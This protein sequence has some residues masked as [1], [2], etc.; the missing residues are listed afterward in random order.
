M[1]CIWTTQRAVANGLSQVC[2]ISQ[3]WG[4]MAGSEVTLS[5]SSKG[6]WSF[7]SFLCFSLPMRSTGLLCYELFPDV[8]SPQAPNLKTKWLWTQTSR[9]RSQDKPL[10]SLIS[11][12]FVTVMGSGLTQ[13][14]MELH[15]IQH[16]CIF[17][18]PLQRVS[19]AFDVL[20]SKPLL[21]SISLMSSFPVSDFW[22]LIVSVNI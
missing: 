16:G 6:E 13:K 2:S 1:A 9:T 5:V 20:G 18:S 19:F 3:R 10:C 4:L 15:T 12:G 8:L 17:K 7:L 22:L 21:S 14:A 11:S